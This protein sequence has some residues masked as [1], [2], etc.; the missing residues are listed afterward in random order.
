V[1]GLVLACG[2]AT[3]QTIEQA[4]GASAGGASV[5]SSG[6]ATAAKAGAAALASTGGSAPDAGNTTAGGPLMV[7][8]EPMCFTPDELPEEWYGA[9]SA[10][11]SGREC[12]VGMESTFGIGYCYFQVSDPQPTAPPTGHD[13]ECCYWLRVFHCR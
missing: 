10:G 1:G 12:P 6:A 8:P 9:N 3:R 13:G 11:A 4:A 5:G 7:T 2:G